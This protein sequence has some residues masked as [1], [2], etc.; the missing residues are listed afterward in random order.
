MTTAISINAQGRLTD[1]TPHITA[2][3]F[4]LVDGSLALTPVGSLELESGQHQV[5]VKATD[6]SNNEA[7]AVLVVNIMPEASIASSQ[8][9]SAGGQYSQSLLLSGS[10]ATYPVEVGYQLLVN[11][12]AVETNSTLISAAMQGT[13]HFNIPTHVTIS[14]NVVLQLS[15]ASNVLNTCS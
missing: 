7:T 12:V 6:L 8:K 3:A 13:I 5:T 14:D 9:V 1:I 10:A 2:T 15:S 4:D 11:D